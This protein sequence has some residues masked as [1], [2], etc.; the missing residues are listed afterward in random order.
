MAHDTDPSL[1]GRPPP[2]PVTVTVTA[3]F[4][5]GTTDVE[6]IRRLL[7]LTVGAELLHLGAF[8]QI[9]PLGTWDVL[10]TVEGPGR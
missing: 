4:T 10:A 2:D 1:V 3:T 8:G 7:E 9:G 5:L 6:V